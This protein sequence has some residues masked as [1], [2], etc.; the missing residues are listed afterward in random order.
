[1][2]RRGHTTLAA[3]WFAGLM[4]VGVAG[5]VPASAQEAEPE[6]E[7]EVQIDAG[8]DVEVNVAER[9]GDRVVLDVVI[10]PDVAGGRLDENAVGV[11]L[12]GA[13]VAADIERLGGDEVVVVIAIDVSGST[14]G[15]VLDGAVA[16]AADFVA[17]LPVGTRVGLVEFGP[18]ARL[19]VAP[20]SSTAEV[21]AALAELEADGETS[22]F[23]GAALAATTAAAEPAAVRSVVVFSDGRDT[24]SASGPTAATDVARGAGATIDL[25]ALESSDFDPQ[26]LAGLAVDGR[27]WPVEQ[28]TQLAAAFTAIA[29]RLGNRFVVT[30]DDVDE[31]SRLVVAVRGDDGVRRL[32]V[33]VAPV[34]RSDVGRRP[35]GL[36]RDDAPVRLLETIT[37]TPSIATA[38]DALLGDRTLS[39]GLG[40][41]GA[42]IFLAAAAVAWPNRRRPETTSAAARLGR[43]RR[44]KLD[45]EEIVG[46]LSSIADAGLARAGATSRLA[47]KLEQSGSTLRPG[48]F[49]VMVGA[50]AMVTMVVAS[51]MLGPTLG[52]AAAMATVIGSKV[53][54]DMRV[55]KLRAAFAEQLGSTLQLLASNLRV[56]HGLL[57][58]VDAVGAES[59]APT[60]QELR[61]VTGEVRLGRDVGD[62]LRAMGERMDNADFRWVVQAI[63]I[64]REVGGDLGEVLDNVGSTIRDRNR[65]KGQIEALS[66]D[67]RISAA[68]MMALPFCVGGLMM[69]TT[70]EYLDELTTRGAGRLLLA[71]GAL[72]MISGGAWL[73][74]IVKLEF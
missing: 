44:P 48:E 15:E 27:V 3:L 40:S 29:D 18:T 8:P 16:A 26:T 52:L 30:V 37:V 43:R 64:H 66:A 62:A 34:E 39:Y 24:A 25:V 55:R 20:T 22:L 6:P 56:G 67:G 19:L 74:S 21:S 72:L 23:D 63:E 13:Y 28:P 59:E 61:R 54:L 65:L 53:R 71:F 14:A 50:A 4:V 2:T 9:L 45:R 38:P 41:I 12:D 7:P 68:V 42:G 10:P 17:G 35:S 5:A 49:M 51:L 58:S 47:T 33:E 57:Q 70:P 32:P 73:K 36:G 11:I 69:F 1:M 46:R 60:A 31:E